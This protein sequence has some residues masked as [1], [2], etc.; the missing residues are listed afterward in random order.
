MAACCSISVFKL[1][2][3]ELSTVVMAEFFMAFYHADLNWRHP[4]YCLKY[5]KALNYYDEKDVG[6]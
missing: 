2:L 1:T 5:S 6:C 4:T 3:P